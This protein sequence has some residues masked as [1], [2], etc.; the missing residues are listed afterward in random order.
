MAAFALKKFKYDAT[1]NAQY[2][3]D[4]PVSAYI[5]IVRICT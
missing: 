4:I 3:N 5:L 1:Y 2:I